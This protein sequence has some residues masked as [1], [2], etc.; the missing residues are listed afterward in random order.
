MNEPFVDNDMLKS[1]NLPEAQRSGVVTPPTGRLADEKRR[2]M[3][4]RRIRDV[5]SLPEVTNEIV[6][7]LGKPATPASEIAKLI[8]FDPGLTSRVLRMVNSAAYG[9]NRQVSSIQHGIMIL[10]FN[11]VRGLV[12][13][14]S[15]FK[16]F[17]KANSGKGLDHQAFWQHSL[18]CAMLARRTCEYYQLPEQEDAFS[19]GML[20]DIGKL[21]LDQFFQEDYQVVLSAAKE[22]EMP[23]HGQPFLDLE[24]EILGTNHTD[25]GVY[26]SQKWKLPPGLTEVIEQHHSPTESI[27]SKNLTYS[28]A[29]GNELSHQVLQDEIIEVDNVSAP[30]REFF[31]LETRDDLAYIQSELDTYRESVSKLLESFDQ[32]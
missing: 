26:L 7:L 20:H 4:L 32:T 14:A 13:S 29:L 30:L 21:V 22:H 1:L 2:E 16:I 15:M 17:D 24:T 25:I 19:A 8:S 31:S 11:T 12:L 5:P 28:V 23:P 18:L 27:I 6:R 10:G 3:A 9:M